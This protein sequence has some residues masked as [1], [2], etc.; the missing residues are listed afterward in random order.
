MTSS[1]RPT[2]LHVLTASFKEG[3][4]RSDIRQV[5]EILLSL[6]SLL[7][8]MSSRV[9]REQVLIEQLQKSHKE[10]SPLIDQLFVSGGDGKRH[11]K[12]APKHSRLP[13]LDE[14]PIHL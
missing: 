7:K 3:S 5:K 13:N 2:R 8:N 1:I 9:P 11:R 10:L 4:G 12:R 14:G 6:D